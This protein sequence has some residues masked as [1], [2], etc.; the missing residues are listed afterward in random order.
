MKK[1]RRLKVFL[2][3]LLAVSFTVAVC[4][5]ASAAELFS[6]YSLVWSKSTST[7]VPIKYY[8]NGTLPDVYSNNLSAGISY[9]TSAFSAV[10][11]QRVYTDSGEGKIIFQ[12][13]TESW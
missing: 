13:P 8:I 10:T 11:A 3:L 9:W 7:S 5:K 1:H 2:S 6:P 4:P 12:C